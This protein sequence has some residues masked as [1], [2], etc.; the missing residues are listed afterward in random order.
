MRL[1]MHGLCMGFVFSFR[2]LLLHSFAG[3]RLPASRRFLPNCRSLRVESAGRFL[4]IYT[5]SRRPLLVQRVVIAVRLGGGQQT[6][7]YFLTFAEVS[8]S[9]LRIPVR[10][11]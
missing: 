3:Y 4:L 10:L 8:Y 6:Q 11:P 1:R 5:D 2:R 7:G 9:V